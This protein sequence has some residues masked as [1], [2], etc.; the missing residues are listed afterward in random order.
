MITVSGLVPRSNDLNNKA[1]E[2]NH[3]LVL[4]HKERN[5]LFLSHDEKIGPSRHLNNS[6]FKQLKSNGINTFN[7]YI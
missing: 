7:G 5:I 1:N 6:T 3:C 4:M 2:V